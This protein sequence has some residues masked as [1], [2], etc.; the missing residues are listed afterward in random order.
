MLQADPLGC[1]V[2]IYPG[3]SQ[4]WHPR[5][6]QGTRQQV[7]RTKKRRKQLTLQH[8]ALQLALDELEKKAKAKKES[9]G[10]RKAI[11][12]FSKRSR[13]HL[14]KKLYSLSQPPKF[15]ITLT[16]PNFFPAC[17]EEWKRHL[18]NFRRALSKRFLH[19]WFFWKLEPQKRGAPHY[20]LIGDLNEEV[21]ITDFRHLVSA[22]WYQVCGRI[23]P[24][25]LRAGTEVKIIR[26]SQ[27]RLQ[28]YVSKYIS[29]VDMSDYEQWS[30][31]GRFWGVLGKNNLPEPLYYVTT[32]D[33]AEYFVLRRLVRRW[34]KKQSLVSHNYAKRLSHIPTFFVF[35][36]GPVVHRFL[37][38][39]IGAPPF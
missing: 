19:Y 3:Y 36:P 21:D 37:D 20:H 30:T 26:Q 6:E 23:D 15:L 35:M 2:A 8:P 28:T 7:V 25:H 27:K 10:T 13:L 9:R 17:A 31:P 33:E 12:R 4:F 24:K 18:D 39:I 11:T 16:Y 32:L 34:L 22:L 29:K 14:Q 5:T 1:Q 38:L